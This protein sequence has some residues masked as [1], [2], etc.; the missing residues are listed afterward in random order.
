MAKFNM[1]T[2]LM[3]LGFY[4]AIQLVLPFFMMKQYGNDGFANGYR[5]ALVVSLV[6]FEL[7]GKNII[8][9]KK[10]VSFKM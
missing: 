7:F 1:E 3:V 8:F 5:L 4:V 2:A 6:L 9:S 10:N